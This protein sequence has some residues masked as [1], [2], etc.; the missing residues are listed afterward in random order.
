MAKPLLEGNISYEQHTFLKQLAQK[1]HDKSIA[2]GMEYINQNETETRRLIMSIAQ[3]SN[4]L[5]KWLDVLTE[6][7]G[8]QQ[9][10]S[11]LDRQK[12][13]SLGSGKR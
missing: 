10:Q 3:E 13:Q 5:Q 7:G 11:Y 9:L 6:V 12:Q 4:E 2:L 1:I 8:Y